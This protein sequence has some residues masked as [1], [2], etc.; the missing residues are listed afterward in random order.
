MQTQERREAEKNKL[1]RVIL[2]EAKEIAATEGWQNVTIR[3]ICEKIHYTAPVIYQH[4]ENK[5]MILCALRVEA[6]T[7]MHERFE[8]IDK[9]YDK[10]EKRLL[11]YAMAWWHFAQ[12][13]PELYQVMFNLQ[14]VL[15]LDIGI[16][17]PTYYTVADFYKT[18]F[19]KINIKVK[20][21]EKLQLEFCDNIIAII[22]GFIS[23]NMVGKIR[24]GKDNAEN[25]FKNA[26]QRFIHSIQD[27]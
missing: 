18:A 13:N 9:K 22:H 10:P 26:L 24:S 8:E 11:K 25:V 7:L 2:R 27:K 16:D 6:M 23:L 15:C 19:S 14:G 17:K 3:K 21:S 1:K 20:H 4:F 12:T 5:E